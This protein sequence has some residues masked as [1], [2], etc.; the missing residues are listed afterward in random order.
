MIE[1]GDGQFEGGSSSAHAIA[2]SGLVRSKNSC[3]RPGAARGPIRLSAT[4]PARAARPTSSCSASTMKPPSRAGVREG[5]RRRERHAAPPRRG[6]SRASRAAASSS[7]RVPS[8][9]MRPTSMITSRSATASTSC[10]QVRGEQHRA[11]AIG[12]VAQELAHPAHPSAGR[13][14]WPA[15]RGSG[16]RGP[17]AARARGRGAD[18]C[19]ASTGARASAAAERSRPTRSS[20]SSTRRGSTPIICAETISASRPRRPS[21]CAAASSRIPTRRPGLGKVAIATA[22]DDRPSGVRLRQP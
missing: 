6:R 17:R 21:C 4:P 18:A 13:A 11:A 3:S 12:E 19:P 8:A 14:R 22:E 2:S 5:S 7:A 20:R 10:K 1:T 9:T 15:R 16:P